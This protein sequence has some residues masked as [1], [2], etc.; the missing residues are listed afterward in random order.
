MGETRQ[1][2]QVVGRSEQRTVE[3]RPEGGRA[4]PPHPR[5]SRAPGDWLVQLHTRVHTQRVMHTPMD[6]RTHSDGQAYIHRAVHT[7]IRT[8]H[9]EMCTCMYK[10]TH[11]HT[12]AWTVVRVHVYIHTCTQVCTCT[13]ICICTDV[14]A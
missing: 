11:M 10:H 14:C 4:Y 1:H 8:C 2:L 7:H 3:L 9:T 5:I 6:A 12:H 13:Q